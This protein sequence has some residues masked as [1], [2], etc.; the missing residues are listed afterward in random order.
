MNIKKIAAS[1]L[2]AGMLTGSATAFATDNTD[3]SSAPANRVGI[4]V[5]PEAISNTGNGWVRYN[6]LSYRI[7]EDGT[8]D[9]FGRDLGNAIQYPDDDFGPIH[10][11]IDAVIPNEI[12]GMKV[13]SMGA[14]D[15]GMF[16]SWTEDISSLTIPENITFI[17][18]GDWMRT[19]LDCAFVEYDYVLTEI[20]VDE[21]NKY[22]CAVNNVLFNKD[23]TNLILYPALPDSEYS[24]PDSVTK[25]GTSAF[26]CN[27]N[28][29]SIT[30]PDSVTEIGEYAFAWCLNLSSIDLS[31][32]TVNIGENAFAYC[33]P[34]SITI[35][36]S[37][38]TI[39]K[40]A[41]SGCYELSD[42][43]YNGT[44][45]EW[46]KIVIEE[47]N[48]P[49][50]N[51]TIHFSDDTSA[52]DYT[53]APTDI[54]VTAPENAFAVTVILSV[55]PITS[56]TTTDRFAYDIKFVNADGDEVQ[57]VGEVTV[58]FPVPETLIGKTV[59]VFRAE[60]GKF[61]DMKAKVEDG[62]AV[63]A[64]DHFSEYILTSENLN[65]VG[66]SGSSSDSGTTN[67]STSSTPST[68]DT[69]S[70]EPASSETSSEPASS[71]PGYVESAA[72][73]PDASST[74]PTAPE[75]NPSTGVAM[76]VLPIV[77]AISAVI[78]I[79]KRK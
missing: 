23:K 77:A 22:Y 6:D 28:L 11:I 1:L 20:N 60:N 2:A 70:S 15:T 42:V 47:R 14:V 50:V 39:G 72:S 48:E 66:D 75:S 38:K 27:R 67:P 12:D 18:Q 19:R 51:A 79:K 76:S 9:F 3:T 30:V 65:G 25:I 37:V 31:K 29:V 55:T 62:Y 16:S 56:D 4:V 5:E 58:K 34:T 44:R 13:T 26:M 52:T 46:E 69:S 41:F 61:T 21:K 74:A 17:D 63:F 71:T 32:N 54:T 78:V 45:E 24:I 53:D 35:P 40:E 33:C 43:Y 64:T 7:K 36:S 8:L 49:L 59:Y 68:S 57:P 10:N 73:T